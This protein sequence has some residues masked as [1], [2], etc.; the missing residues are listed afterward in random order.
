MQ[1][2]NPEEPLK[3]SGVEYDSYDSVYAAEPLYTTNKT[4]I[5]QLTEPNKN[6]IEGIT[7][8]WRSHGLGWK[9][10]DTFTLPTGIK[11][12]TFVPIGAS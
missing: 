11:L 6:R 9:T 8:Y 12:H 3:S 7:Y 2:F 5:Y 1:V 4:N 10:V